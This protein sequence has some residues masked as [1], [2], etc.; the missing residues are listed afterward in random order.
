MYHSKTNS[1][2]FHTIHHHTIRHQ[3][4]LSSRD[5]SRLLSGTIAF[6]SQQNFSLFTVLLHFLTGGASNYYHYTKSEGISFFF[7]NCSTTW[8]CKTFKLQYSNSATKA[9]LQYSQNNFICKV[10][11]LYHLSPQTT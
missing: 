4:I 6:S 8:A 5:L 11:Y 9:F 7:S 1:R 2:A 3:G 10:I